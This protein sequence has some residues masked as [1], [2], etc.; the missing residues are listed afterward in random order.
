MSPRTNARVAGAT[1]LLYI[2]V[3]IGPLVL[4][5]RGRLVPAW[6]AWLGVGSSV[7]LAVLLPLRLAG[8]AP[9]AVAQAAWVPMAVFEIALAP[10]LLVR[11]VAVPARAQG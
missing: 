10:W 11:G 5:R 4:A 2:A 7:L 6:L 3:G 1:F 8:F 9:D